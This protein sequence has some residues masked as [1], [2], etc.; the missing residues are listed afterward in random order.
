MFY[1]YRPQG[2]TGRRG[3]FRSG[4]FFMAWDMD[5]SG[6][7]G[8]RGRAQRRFDSKELQLL[9]LKLISD[10]P[11]HGYDLIREIEERSGGAYVPSAGVIYPTLTLLEDM[12][13]IAVQAAKGARKSY[14]TTDAGRAYLADREDEVADILSRLDALGAEQ[15]RTE[16][17]SVRR[18]MGNLR[19]A[20]ANRM[21]SGADEATLHE[22]VELL[23][24]VARK[25]E[26][27]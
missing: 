22:I 13:L 21:A 18:A 9:L 8:G 27:L 25:I 2:C 26:R 17:S 14:E 3:R 16:R 11:R 1:S 19:H 6:M 10:A 15:E 5:F 24:E 20:L 12:E 7:Q 4:P 23:D